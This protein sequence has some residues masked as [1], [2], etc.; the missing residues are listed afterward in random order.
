MA[1]STRAMAASSAGVSGPGGRGGHAGRPRDGRSGLERG[2]QRRR[3]ARSAAVD[4]RNWELLLFSTLEIA[5]R[6][7]ISGHGDRRSSAAM[8]SQRNRT[9]KRPSAA[10]KP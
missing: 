3:P 7:T 6:P 2:G 10:N 4:G 1:C 9:V 5:G 8:I